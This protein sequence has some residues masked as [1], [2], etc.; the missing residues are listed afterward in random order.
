[1]KN[2]NVM[3]VGA[4]AIALSSCGKKDNAGAQAQGPTPYPVV[5]VPTRVVTSYDEYPTNIEGVVNNEVRA[6][7]QGYI[8]EVYV[9]EGQ[10]VQAG[11]PLFRLETNVLTQN[12][13]AARSGVGAAQASVKSAQA[14][15]NAAKASVNAAQV[16][17]DKLTPLV[18]KNIISN[19]QLE[20]AKANLAKA[21]A[22]YNQ[23]LAAVGQAQAGVTQAQANY[24]GA[25]ANVDYSV[26]RAP[27]SGV[28]GSINFR[29]G[30][31]VGPSDPTAITTVSN[32][33]KVY[34]YFSMNEKEYLNFISKSEGATLKEKL[35]KIPAVDL[36][37]ANGEIYPEKGKIQTVTGQINPTTG[38]ID[39]RVSFNNAAKIL[40]NGN[41]G[42]IRVPKTYVDVLVVPEA[43]TFEQQGMTYVYKVTKDTAYATP[44][45]VVERANNIAVV[46]DGVK[47]GDKVVAQGVGKLRDKTAVKPMP[48]NFDTIVNSTKTVF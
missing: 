23:A 1:M 28:L 47:K 19:V 21:Q 9:D 25:Q 27:I 43:A 26:V 7:I 2:V 36:V 8:T 17:V 15:V 38:T 44:I 46:K 20:T 10:Y 35:D 13:D 48:A 31:L 24:K 34:A 14:N 12:A 42:R 18:Q 41:S 11:Q 32:T 40:A 3:M 29:Q 37:L 5:D 16:E 6:K 4:L 45:T 33:S 22:S 39:F 30:T